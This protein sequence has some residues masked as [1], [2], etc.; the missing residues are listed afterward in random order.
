MVSLANVSHKGA[1]YLGDAL[2]GAVLYDPAT[3]FTSFE[4]AA[5][6]LKSGFSISPKHLPLQVGVFQFPLLSF[7]TY[8]G[9]LLRLT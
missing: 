4:Y 5:Q 1:V 8:R 7:E 6:W 2:V 3:K 9:Y